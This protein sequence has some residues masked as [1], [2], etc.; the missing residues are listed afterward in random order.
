MC[1]NRVLVYRNTTNQVLL[2]DSLQHVGC[3]GPV[4]DA[5]RVNDR[6]GSLLAD[7]QAVSLGS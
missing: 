1:G 2:N 7:L 3:A 5:I 6:Y 4:P